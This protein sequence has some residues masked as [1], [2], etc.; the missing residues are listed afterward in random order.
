MNK[1]IVR[2]ISNFYDIE[3]DNAL[4]IVGAEIEVT[5]ERYEELAKY[6]VVEKLEVNLKK[7]A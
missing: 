2:V 5:K 1:I 6:K 7:D 3:A 4:R